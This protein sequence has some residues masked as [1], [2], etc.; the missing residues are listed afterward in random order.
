M[1]GRGRIPR[2]ILFAVNKTTTL[3][4]EG[5]D[6]TEFLRFQCAHFKEIERYF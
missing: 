4:C 1:K 3:P 6:L 5:A 2:V